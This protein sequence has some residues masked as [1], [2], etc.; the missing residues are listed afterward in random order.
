MW[1]HDSLEESGAAGLAPSNFHKYYAEYEGLQF[2]TRTRT[3]EKNSP[4]LGQNTHEK[5][6]HFDIFAFRLLVSRHSKLALSFRLQMPNDS[7]VGPS[8]Q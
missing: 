1:R 5:I 2:V 6:L 8:K 3:Q 4:P 7:I